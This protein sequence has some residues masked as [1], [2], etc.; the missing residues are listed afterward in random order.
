[1]GLGTYD[2]A[3][4]FRLR[5]DLALIQTLDFFTPIVDEPYAFGQVA[6]ANALSDVYAMGGTPLT[7]M[8]IICFPI[9]SMDVS[10]LREI[11]Q[12]GLEKIKEA[13]AFLVGGHSVEDDELKY[14]LS[15]TGVVHPDRFLTNRGAKPGDRLVL[16]KPIGTGIIN[17]AIKGNLA[18]PDVIAQVTGLMAR[19]NRWPIES[20]VDFGVSACTDVTGFGLLGHACEM[21]EDEPLGLRIDVDQVPVINGVKDFA[22]M[23][24]VPAGTHRNRSFREGC[25][26]TAPAVDAILMDILFDPQTSGGL[27]IAA[28]TEG[29][30]RLVEWLQRDGCEQAA[31]IGEFVPKPR[32]KILIQTS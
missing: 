26:E 8:N 30:N 11:L 14:G 27:L 2:D 29:A 21:I 3:G 12:G 25:L 1:V 5:D 24:M 6:A 7:A 17:T 4:V 22:A 31:V 18:G 23:G 9:Q 28:E 13:G 15:V 32:G 19:L 16:T 10:V 20:S